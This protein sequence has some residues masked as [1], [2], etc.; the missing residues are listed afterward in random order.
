MEPGSSQGKLLLRTEDGST[1]NATVPW[2]QSGESQ[3][4]PRPGLPQACPFL[5]QARVGCEH[6]GQLWAA[7]GCFGEES[8]PSSLPIYLTACGRLC[9][10]GRDQPTLAGGLTL[11]KRGV[12]YALATR[13]QHPGPVPSRHTLVFKAAG[14]AVDLGDRGTDS[15]SQ[16]PVS[17]FVPLGPDGAQVVAGCHLLKQ[18]LGIRGSASRPCHIPELGT[19]GPP[20][21]REGPCSELELRKLKTYLKSRGRPGFV[22]AHQEHPTQDDRDPTLAE[23]EAAGHFLQAPEGSSYR[24]PGGGRAILAP[25]S[26]PVPCSAAHFLCSCTEGCVSVSHAVRFTS[27]A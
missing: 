15:G 10:S 18:H 11:R 19:H 6:S 22:P 9:P 12:S 21:S 14:H 25:P 17:L 26:P 1:K 8:T 23:R 5:P 24:P 20:S 4:A 2:G 16:L 13:I 27:T 7:L 3:G